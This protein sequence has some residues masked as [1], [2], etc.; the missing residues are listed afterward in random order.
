MHDFTDGVSAHYSLG[1][2]YIR[3]GNLDKAYNLHSLALSERRDLV[4]DTY[5]T[6][7]ALHKVAW[8]LH[9]LEDHKGAE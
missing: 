6:A 3:Q 2:F 9:R 8:H 1:N 7:A 5:R 4:G